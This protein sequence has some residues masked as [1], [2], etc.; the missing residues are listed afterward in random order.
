MRLKEGIVD[1][2]TEMAKGNKDRGNQAGKDVEGMVRDGKSCDAI[3][4]E[5]E[6]QA[7]DEGVPEDEIKDK[8]GKL[9]EAVDEEKEKSKGNKGGK[10]KGGK[11]KGGKGKGGEG[12]E[13]ETESAGEGKQKE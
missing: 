9:A 2:V 13:D 7:R 10:R 8:M 1:E 3:G 5:I 6:R 12:D 4:A 11:R